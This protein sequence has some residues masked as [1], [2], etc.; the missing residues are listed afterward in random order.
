MSSSCPNCGERVYNGHCTW[1]H[2]EHYIME[3][4]YQNDEPTQFSEE[5]VEK[6]KAQDKEAKEIRRKERLSKLKEE[7]KMLG[8]NNEDI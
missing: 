5:F 4:S 7:R 6:V 2:E 1:C 8:E 3:Q